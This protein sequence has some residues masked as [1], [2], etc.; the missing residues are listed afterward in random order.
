MSE[1]LHPK[2]VDASPRK[3]SHHRSGYT[4][5]RKPASTHRTHGDMRS[6]QVQMQ[7]YNLSDHVEHDLIRVLSHVHGIAALIAAT[8]SH[9][10]LHL[11]VS[12][13]C[14]QHAALALAL[15]N[16]A[17]TI[18]PVIYRGLRTCTVRQW[19]H[20]AP[21]TAGAARTTH[22]NDSREAERQ[23]GDGFR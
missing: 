14:S 1:L 23:R 22:G 5:V 21:A 2:G 9:S 11:F 8:Y 3:V 13:P 6:M 18:F 15:N 12:A 10:S 16:T 7:E 20:P 19:H 4:F 17:C